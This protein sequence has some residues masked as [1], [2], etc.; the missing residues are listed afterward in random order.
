MNLDTASQTTHTGYDGYRRRRQRG[1]S[2]R[3]Q[4]NNKKIGVDDGVS[5]D[6][7]QEPMLD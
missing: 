5:K 7:L 6:M 3:S 4:I 2:P 1:R